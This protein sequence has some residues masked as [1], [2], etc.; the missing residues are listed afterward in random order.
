MSTYFSS[1]LFYSSMQILSFAIILTLNKRYNIKANKVLAA[2]LIMMGV[3]FFVYAITG[4]DRVSPLLLLTYVIGFLGGPLLFFYVR[5]YLTNKYSFKKS[6]LW[7]LIPFIVQLG[8]WCYIFYLTPQ[9]SSETEKDLT[10]YFAQRDISFTLISL[11]YV[12]LIFRKIQ[13]YHHLAK[14][15]YSY[16]NDRVL[17]WFYAFITL[18]IVSPIIVSVVLI[19]SKEHE[20]FFNPLIFSVFSFLVMLIVLMRPEI[21]QGIGILAPVETIPQSNTKSQAL[22]E[23][24]KE[25]LFAELKAHIEAGQSYLDPDLK[26]RSLAEDL[27]TNVNYLSQSIN[28]VSN[29]S[30]CDFINTY[31]IEHAAKMLTDTTFSKY[32]IDGI[33]SEVGFKSKSAFYNAFK[34][35]NHMS[36]VAFKKMHGVTVD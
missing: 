7:H 9:A 34:K 20:L 15:Q 4:F 19:Y 30:F 33:A 35:I 13:S 8:I 23:A 2:L 27:N 12:W 21:Y 28:G 1:I 36:P 29:K 32:T 26:L 18:L 17:K 14:E 6:H 24:Q 31:R 22:T 11:Y 3:A 16:T 25:K 5:T 10:F